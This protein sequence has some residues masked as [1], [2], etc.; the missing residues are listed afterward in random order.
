M[1]KN[2]KEIE[3]Q[4][5]ADTSQFTEK[6]DAA[7]KEIISL[8]KELKLNKTQMKNNSDSV[9]LLTQRQSILSKES[10]AS[11]NKIDAL[12]S[13]LDVAKKTFGENSK[14]VYNL[15]NKITDAKNQ[16][17]AIQNEIQDT[18]KKLDSLSNK[19]DD[20]SNEFDSLS[21]KT[22]DCGNEL[23]KTSQKAEKAKGG[24]TVFKGVISDLISNGLTAL[25]GK[26]KEGI[27]WIAGLAGETREFRQDMNTLTTAFD[28]ANFSSETAQ[29]TWKD[30]Y[31]IF[32]EDDRAVEAANNISRMAE[33][34]KD[35]DEWVKIT[36]GIWGTYQDALPVESLAE[37]AGETAKTA[38]V[39]GT[40][41]DALNWNSE[42][43]K[44]FSKYMSED[45][46]TAEDAFNVALSKCSNE[47]ER[48]QLITQTLT[49]LYGDAADKYNETAGNIIEAN[50]A[51]ADLTTVQAE[52]GATIEPLSN[53]FKIGFAGILGGFNG[54]LQGQQLGTEKMLEGIS[55]IA[56]TVTKVATDVL[57]GVMSSLLDGLV[58]ILPQVGSLAVTLIITLVNSLLSQ[59]PSILSA[60]VKIIITLI[61][62]ITAAVPQLLPLVVTIIGDIISTLKNGF[63]DLIAVA[64]DL[65][66]SIVDA[67][68]TVIPMVVQMIP[69]I[70]DAILHCLETSGFIILETAIVAFSSIIDAIPIILPELIA[71][72]PVIINSL[73]EMLYLVQEDLIMVVTDL[74]MAIVDAIPV[75][76]PLLQNMLPSIITAVIDLLG[77][78][79]PTILDGAVN[80]FTA[81]IEAIPVIL[82]ALITMLPEIIASILDALVTGTPLILNGAVKAFNSIVQA[83]PKVAVSLLAAGKNMIKD[84]LES[85][86]SIPESIG[87]LF[88]GIKAKIKVP[89]I[90]VSYSTDGTL[91]KVADAIGLPGFPKLNITWNKDGHFFRGK[92]LEVRGYAEAGDSEYALPLNKKT[93]DPLAAGIVNHM[94]TQTDMSD[95]ISHIDALYN[96][97]RTGNNTIKDKFIDAVANRLAIKLDSRELGRVVRSY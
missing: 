55:G 42:A 22:D 73:L 44:M 79:I 49:A 37:A 2:K 94:D 93:L 40:L 75:L 8:T 51:T 16:F 62:G 78:S 66:L 54:L 10:E 50:K 69:K 63:P 15:Q 30:L 74:F 76:M 24:F 17:A 71:A 81:I 3:A 86:N 32:G 61:N 45:V 31:G 68:P 5:K 36:T 1:A 39:T 43:A 35:L 9:E 18:D 19:V 12:E 89:T 95:V 27:Q 52:L 56:D 28:A 47:Q 90:K 6:V 13:K 41:A 25:V 84:F 67:I 58:S 70:I 87:K 21:D 4:F 80:A 33:N 82:P 72:I 26:C 64:T 97:V 88:D 34:E 57:P 23:E 7:G 96:E 91:G 38:Q 20:C 65:F 29:K 11:K 60:G 83:I 53:Q 77:S 92:T 85:F 14:E 46:T 59:L 48:Q